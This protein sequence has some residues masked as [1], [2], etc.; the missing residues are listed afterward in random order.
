MLY[1]SILLSVWF[2]FWLWV[3]NIIGFENEIEYYQVKC[4][5]CGRVWNITN[6]EQ[7]HCPYCG[8]EI[9]IDD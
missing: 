1:V 6:P 7:N 9:K 8:E 5:H 4:D 3:Q 2:V